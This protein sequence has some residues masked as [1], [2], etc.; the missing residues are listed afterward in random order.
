MSQETKVFWLLAGAFLVGLL[1][2]LIPH[3]PMPPEKLFI[4]VDGRDFGMTLEWYVYLAGE[5]ISRMVIF[6]AFWLVTKMNVVHL[7][8]LIECADLIDFMVIANKPW[9]QI[10]G[11]DVEFN[12]MKLCIIIIAFVH[13]WIT[14]RSSG[15]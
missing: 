9:F 2:D 5:K 15:F 10:L 1:F 14:K 7:F 11:F 3:T 4:L 8:F 6:Y 12:T 13:T